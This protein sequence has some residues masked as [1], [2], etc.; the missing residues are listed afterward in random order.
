MKKRKMKGVFGCVSGDRSVSPWTLTDNGMMWVRTG[1]P[2]FINAKHNC[3]V[4]LMSTTCYNVFAPDGVTDE[5]VN[6][7]DVSYDDKMVEVVKRE[8]DIV[9]VDLGW[10]VDGKSKVRPPWW[11][12]FVSWLNVVVM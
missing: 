6:F 5:F 12:R 10:T 2:G 7:C 9:L 4:A 1:P 3:E 8:I 11:K